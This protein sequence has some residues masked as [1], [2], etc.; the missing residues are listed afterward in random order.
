MRLCILCHLHPSIEN[1]HI[2]PKFVVKRLKQGAPHGT[3]RHSDN[4]SYPAQDGWKTDYLCDGC[5]KTFMK[6]EDW[7][8][9]KIYDPFLNGTRAVFP[10]SEQL[11]LFAASLHFRNIRYV[12]DQRP[13]AAMPTALLDLY[14]FLHQIC[15]T[16]SVPTEEFHAYL[17]FL[18]PITDLALG[19]PPGVNAYISDA[20]DGRIFDWCVPGYPTAWVSYAKFHS[21]ILLCSSVDLDLRGSGVLDATRIRTAGSL[22]SGVQGRHLLNAIRSDFIAGAARIQAGY[23]GIPANQHAK[24]VAKI[25][26]EPNIEEYRAHKAFLADQQLLEQWNAANPHAFLQPTPVPGVPDFPSA[27]QL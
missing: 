9:R 8:C 5:E 17:E 15:L 19:F 16:Q 2:F 10:M 24:N 11:A 6:W 1:S 22:D 23:G 3:L 4:L 27:N 13:S 7:V 18:Q 25:L 21:M 26:G 12:L 14:V 20:L